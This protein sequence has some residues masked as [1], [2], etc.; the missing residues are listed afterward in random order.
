MSTYSFYAWF[1]ASAAEWIRS[2]LF[3]DLTQRW[4]MKLTPLFEVLR[5]RLGQGTLNGKTVHSSDLEMRVCGRTKATSTW[6]GQRHSPKHRTPDFPVVSLFDGALLYCRTRNITFITRYCVLYS[7][8]TALGYT[9]I[10]CNRY[11]IFSPG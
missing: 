1:Q 8:Q 11:R 10:H 3:W 5:K 4:L 9:T 7:I 6:S 2:P